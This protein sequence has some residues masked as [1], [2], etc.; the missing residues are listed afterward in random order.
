MLSESKQARQAAPGAEQENRLNLAVSNLLHLAA[1]G[2]GE[3]GVARESCDSSKGNNNVYFDNMDDD[4]F[5]IKTYQTKDM[6]SAEAERQVSHAK[7]RLST[8][9]LDNLLFRAHWPYSNWVGF[10]RLSPY[11]YL[12][13]VCCTIFFWSAMLVAFVFQNMGTRVRHKEEEEKRFYEV[14]NILTST[15]LDRNTNQCLSSTNFPDYAARVVCRLYPATCSGANFEGQLSR[16][17]RDLLVLPPG[18]D[19]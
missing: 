2:A 8:Q 10:W 19:Q 15:F 12:F 14:I 7:H 11:L 1:D 18:H 3:N 5:S 16:S 13:L 17:A 4:L 9:L 6:Y